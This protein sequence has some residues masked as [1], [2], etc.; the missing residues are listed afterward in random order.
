MEQPYFKISRG[1]SRKVQLKQYEPAD[2]FCGA[3][4]YFYEK[5]DPEE[6]KKHSNDLWLF[7]KTEVEMSVKEYTESIKKQVEGEDGPF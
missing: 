6:I 4:Q 5:L 1:F 3:E 2:F 7:C